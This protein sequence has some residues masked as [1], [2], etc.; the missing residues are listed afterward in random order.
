MVTLPSI[1]EGLEIF[2]AHRVEKLLEI[3]LTL[4]EIGLILLEIGLIL[5]EIGLVLLE[6]A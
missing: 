5:K 4:L 6:M 1:S 3:V 2:V